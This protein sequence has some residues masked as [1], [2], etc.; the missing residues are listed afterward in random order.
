MRNEK[1]SLVRKVSSSVH[2]AAWSAKKQKAQEEERLRKKRRN[3]GREEDEDYLPTSNEPSFDETLEADDDVSM[4]DAI[5]TTNEINEDN[6]LSDPIVQPSAER[7]GGAECPT[8]EPNAEQAVGPKQPGDIDW[9]YQAVDAFAAALARGR[10]NNNGP[11]DSV[12]GLEGTVAIPNPANMT[13]EGTLLIPNTAGAA[14]NATAN[15]IETLWHRLLGKQEVTTEITM[16]WIPTDKSKL[17]NEFV[18]RELLILG[19]K[20]S[21]DEAINEEVDKIKLMREAI[22][23]LTKSILKSTIIL[24]A[25]KEGVVYGTRTVRTFEDVARWWASLTPEQARENAQKMFRIQ[26]L[27][28]EDED[29]E[30]DS[31]TKN[32]EKDILKAGN[33]VYHRQPNKA[34]HAKGCIERLITQ[35]KVNQTKVL[36]DKGK[37]S[38]GYYITVKALGGMG[39]SRQP[40][41]K[42]G[43]WRL[44]CTLLP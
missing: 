2:K 41:R 37:R 27:P 12:T 22:V 10:S 5:N 18:K 4:E 15:A 34:K 6:H 28:F 1:G 3:P 20:D 40:R 13:V 31:W 9:A 16:D 33:L 43:E 35:V 23:D 21:S 25:Q 39:R 29:G 8:P 38:H 30:D 14:V 44:G 17:T 11:T 24:Q 26:Q 36:T 19:T 32:L 42:P 7:A